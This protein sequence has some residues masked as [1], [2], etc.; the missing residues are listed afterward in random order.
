MFKGKDPVKVIGTIRQMEIPR[1]ADVR[2]DVPPRLCAIIDRALQRSPA[3]RYA[4][5]H[6]M[7]RDL[8]ALLRDV[9]VPTD[10]QALARSVAWVR[11]RRGDD[12][13]TKTFPA[14][15]ALALAGAA[16]ET[17]PDTSIPLTRR[18]KRN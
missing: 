9:Q 8:A 3:A 6:A 2:S 11:E 12:A 15:R 16:E 5:A 4:T 14:E 10:D 13:I 1:L 18:I 17:I 7:G